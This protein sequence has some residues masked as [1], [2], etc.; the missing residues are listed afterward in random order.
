[1]NRGAKKVKTFN[2]SKRI[3]VESI[4]IGLASPE[5][6]RNWAERTLPNGKVVGQ[7]T[8]SQTVNYKTLRPVKGGLFCERVFGPI[9]DFECSCGRKKSKFLQKFCSE[10]DVEFTSS[11]VRRHRLGYVQLV[12]PVT[13]I[14]YLKGRLSYISNLLGIPRKRVEAV[15]YCTEKLE[16]SETEELKI[17]SP[18]FTEKNFSK[19]PEYLKRFSSPPMFEKTQLFL[20]NKLLRAEHDFSILTDVGLTPSAEKETLP[21]VEKQEVNSYFFDKLNEK[22]KNEKGFES[23][24]AN[25]ASQGLELNNFTNNGDNLDQA[26]IENLTEK[27]LDSQVIEEPINY[28][29]TLEEDKDTKA[30]FKNQ[31]ETNLKISPIP[32]SPETERKKE[33]RVAKSNNI[34]NFSLQEIEKNKAFKKFRQKLILPISQD[35]GG[36]DSEKD[37][38]SFFKYISNSPKPEDIPIP[39][40]VEFAENSE[41]LFSNLNITG[42]EA[43]RKV[44]ANTGALAVR[45]RLVQL[46]LDILDK[47]LKDELFELNEEIHELEDKGFLLLYEER[48]LQR[49]ITQRSKK[50]RRLKLVRDFRRSKARPEWMTLSTLPVLP[51]N[52]RP[53]IQLD[54]DQVA[55]SDLNK[56]YQKILFRNKRFRRTNI[57]NAPYAQRLLQEA[58][59]A[60][61][62]NGK[63]GSDPICASN[64]R[65][66][67]SL[68]DILKGKKGRFRQNLLGKRVDYSGRSV[69]VVGPALKLHQ[70]GLP[71][72]MA[73]ELFQPFLIRRLM[74]KKIVP[75]IVTAKRLIQ[76]QSSLIW[77]VLEQVMQSHPVLLNRAPTLHRLGVQ[78]FQP[79]LVDGR[80]ILLHPLVC[81]AFNADF[82]GDQMA[83]HVPLSFEAR[84]EAWKLMWS[85]NNLLSPATGQPI[86]VPSQDMVLGCYYLTTSALLTAKNSSKKSDELET[87]NVLQ[88]KKTLK[89]N[90]YKEKTT[91]NG[92]KNQVYKAKPDVKIETLDSFLQF[93]SA[94]NYYFSDFNS[95]LKSLSQKNINLHSPIWVKTS[96]LIECEKRL[97]NPLEVRVSPFGH[98]HVIFSTYQYQNDFTGYRMSQYVRT[99][100]GRILLNNLIMSALLQRKE[101]SLQ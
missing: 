95:A 101:L 48:R 60:L 84:A 26:E 22:T 79:K 6:I 20:K 23:K 59:D 5:Q 51:P 63:G 93:S 81:P 66:L 97:K 56:L 73:I 92:G 50:L 39:L 61:I 72:E 27:P 25:S 57:E 55:V 36:W 49:L 74:V 88:R 45:K 38:I 53:I 83:V 14:W 21:S 43:V 85:R 37:R 78:A 9:K 40:Y 29:Y 44:L 13:H 77:D 90:F 7:V 4:R 8:N 34:A 91:E 16:V 76:D 67:K 68:S 30:S 87:T 69:I 62:E 46:N 65:P 10:C 80:A 82:D 70:C 2:K 15:T 17:V 18:F 96:L 35:S 24:L 100:A 89:E 42:T 75:T 33:K 41:T 11:Q 12:S 32:L 99:T 98:S 31:T 19:L 52:L 3:P 64:D 86:L 47:I 71:K 58:V 94:F 54:G 1:M 28:S